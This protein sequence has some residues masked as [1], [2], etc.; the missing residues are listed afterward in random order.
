MK[1]DLNKRL[2]LMLLS[3]TML[4]F[5]TIV[6]WKHNSSSRVASAARP[7]NLPE[8]ELLKKALAEAQFR[9]LR[10]NPTAKKAVQMTL[11]EWLKLVDAELGDDSQKVGLSAD[12]PVYVLAM[13]GSA[14]WALPSQPNPENNNQETEKFDNLTL[15]LN[16]Q[17]G[18]VIW[19]LASPPDRPLPIEP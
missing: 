18:D 3:V 10:G 11:G 12:L 16:A 1:Y 6:V 19:T 7:E 13:R 15:V 4:S 14:E 8:A 5:I 17:T 9:G 2:L